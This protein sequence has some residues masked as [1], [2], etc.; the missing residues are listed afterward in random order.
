MKIAV[1]RSY[2][3]RNGARVKIIN[4]REISTKIDGKLAL[5]PFFVGLLE[6]TRQ[7]ITFQ[8]NGWNSPVAPSY[9]DIVERV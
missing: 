2:T 5:Y 3:M 6:G 9:L 7:K 1:G 4:R 8:E